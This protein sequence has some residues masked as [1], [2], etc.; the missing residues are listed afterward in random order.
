VQWQT[1]YQDEQLLAFIEIDTVDALYGDAVKQ[2][3]FWQHDIAVSY[4]FRETMSVYGGVRN[5][6]DEQPFITNFGYPA[7]PRGRYFY[8]G[9]NMSFGGF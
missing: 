4:A 2:D 7:S 5:V 3:E 9:L 1:Q 8:L 6:T